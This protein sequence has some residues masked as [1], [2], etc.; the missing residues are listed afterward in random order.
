MSWSCLRVLALTQCPSFLLSAGRLHRV[1]A[2]SLSHASSSTIVLCTAR[3][4]ILRTTDS[5]TCPPPHISSSGCCRLRRTGRCAALGSHHAKSSPC[6][7]SHA[8]RCVSTHNPRTP[9]FAV[10]THEKGHRPRASHRSPTADEN[11]SEPA[12]AAHARSSWTHYVPCTSDDDV[13]QLWQRGG[14]Q[15]RRRRRRDGG[16][17][18]AAAHGTRSSVRWASRL[19]MSSPAHAQRVSEQSDPAGRAA[20]STEHDTSSRPRSGAGTHGRN[21]PAANNTRSWL[22]LPFM[23]SSTAFATAPHALH[24]RPPTSPDDLLHDH[25]PRPMGGFGTEAIR[26]LERAKLT[27]VS[28]G[29]VNDHV[30]IAMIKTLR[31]VTDKLFRERYIHRATMLKTLGPSLPAALFV[32]TYVRLLCR[33]QPQ[34]DVSPLVCD[35]HEEDRGGDGAATSTNNTTRRRGVSVNTTAAELRGL[36]SQVEC[37]TVHYQ[38]L[39]LMADI[40]PVERAMVLLA[41]GIHFAL[42]VPLFMLH[43]RMGFRLMAYLYE[44][45]SVVWT[46]MVNDLDMGKI[47]MREV[48]QLAYA[49]WWWGGR[50]VVPQAGGVAAESSS[51]VEGALSGWHEGGGGGAYAGNLAAGAFRP[52]GATTPATGCAAHCAQATHDTTERELGGAHGETTGPALFKEK[53]DEDDGS[54]SSV[55]DGTAAAEEK[56]VDGGRC[57]DRRDDAHGESLERVQSTTRG[58]EGRKRPSAELLTL[59]DVVLLIRADE[60]VYRDCNHLAAT[61]LD[62]QPPHPRSL[63]SRFIRWTS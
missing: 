57:D 3:R 48:P 51:R 45:S 34:C 4:G 28:P 38:I 18:T 16:V 37:A 61:M 26:R 1:S 21:G 9:S 52:T 25:S 62:R 29:R 11:T 46:Q 30:C 42:F 24:R 17:R 23:G 31:W 5:V 32:A 47:E 27:H 59:R 56:V 13:M 41:Q 10:N 2:T 36:L 12:D 63:W 54:G 20:H 7:S 49:Y 40:R 50:C 39:L 22:W 60:M 19:R 58:G 14:R 8:R 33:P 35:Y 55:C 43:P 15:G 44:E 6:P 53:V